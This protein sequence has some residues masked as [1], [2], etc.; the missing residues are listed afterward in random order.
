MLNEF[1]TSKF[2]DD[3]K[4]IKFLIKKSLPI[5][6]NVGRLERSQYADLI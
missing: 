6:D 3:A 5:L 4:K 2:H 1:F